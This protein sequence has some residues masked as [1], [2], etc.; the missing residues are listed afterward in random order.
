ME[1]IG[2]GAT[3]SL[4][5]AKKL[6]INKKP[7]EAKIA[8]KVMEKAWNNEKRKKNNE[9]DTKTIN[10]ATWNVKVLKN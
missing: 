5:E 8:E 10:I 3:N 6:N 4:K 2:D 7:I 1:K 9:V